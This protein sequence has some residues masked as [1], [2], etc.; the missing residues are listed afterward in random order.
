MTQRADFEQIRNERLARRLDLTEVRLGE[1]LS[2]IERLE[3]VLTTLARIKR[4]E[5]VVLQWYRV[6][7]SSIRKDIEA[8]IK[9]LESLEA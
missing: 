5:E 4:V 7:P 6:A 8:R 9:S 3:E 2:R 1:A